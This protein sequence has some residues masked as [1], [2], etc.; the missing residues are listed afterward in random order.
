MG[1]LRVAL[2]AAMLLGVSVNAGFAQDRIS[3]YVA[4]LKMACA[5]ELK[6]YCKGV[7][8]GRGKVL[9][10]LYAREDK[11]SARC[12]NVLVGSVERLGEM[13]TALANVVRVCE[14]DAK[15]LCNGVAAGEG[16]LIGCLT[17]A[18]R[19]VSE[20]CNATLDSAF[21]RPDAR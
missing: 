17:T 12:G 16:N 20:R 5:K 4:A 15:R 1:R 9:A 3:D 8:E 10:C 2:I 14:A 21:L 6:T 7:Q 18:R 11:L 13:L 19:S